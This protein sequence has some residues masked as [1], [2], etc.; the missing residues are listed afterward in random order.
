MTGIRIY[1]PVPYKCRQTHLP[2]QRLRLRLPLLTYSLSLLSSALPPPLALF[3]S[4]ARLRPARRPPSPTPPPCYPRPP[5]PSA[6]VSKP[7][8]SLGYTAPMHSQQASQPRPG[9]RGAAAATPAPALAAA[10][11]GPPETPHRL[12]PG[13]LRLAPRPTGPLQYL[14]VE[15]APRKRVGCFAPTALERRPPTKCYRREKQEQAHRRR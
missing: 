12:W 3:S 13:A 6:T 9:F 4:G 2:S 10:A 7:V 14:Q 1:C 11:R 15:Q 8:N 5:R